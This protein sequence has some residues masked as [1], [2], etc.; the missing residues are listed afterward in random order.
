MKGFVL[1]IFGVLV[2]GCMSHKEIASDQIIAS[3]NNSGLL[4]GKLYSSRCKID[5]LNNEIKKLKSLI[6]S[7]ESKEIVCTSKIVDTLCTDDKFEKV[8]LYTDHWKYIDL[9]RPF[10]DDSYMDG[11]WNCSSVHAYRNLS[12]ADFEDSLQI[13]LVDSIHKYSLPVPGKVH[14]TYRFRNGRNHDGVDLTLRTGDKVRAAF[15]GIV[16]ISMSSRSTGGYGNLLI[17]RH[18]NGLETYYGH[19]SSRLVKVGEMVKA[20]DIIG[21]GGS[22]GRST[23]PHLHFETRYHGQS[24]DPKRVFDF[25]NGKLRSSILVLKKHY[26]SIY[27]HYGQSDSESKKASGRLIYR[28]KSGDT[29]S[30]IAG[31]Y[32]TSIAHLCK[33]NNINKRVILKVGKSLIIR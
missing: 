20:G 6:S 9:G 32:G 13:V 10:T 15:D 4:H 14:S 11:D 3:N 7:D 31:H 19:L 30:R 12:P 2:I 25:K 18:S 16:R 24:F 21:L 23:G 22:T 28:I 17:L 29:L 5:S 1:F 26:Y 8:I 27:S 33:L